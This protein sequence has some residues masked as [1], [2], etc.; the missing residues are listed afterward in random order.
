MFLVPIKLRPS[1]FSPYLILID[2]VIPTKNYCT[3]YYSLLNL[4]LF[5]LCLNS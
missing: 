1:K 4:N 5:N 3:Q 2:F